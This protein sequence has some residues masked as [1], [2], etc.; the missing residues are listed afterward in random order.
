MSEPITWRTGKTVYRIRGSR[1]VGCGEVYFPPKMFCN[2][3]GRES[4]M[5]DVFFGE[6][7]GDIYTA[8]VNR[9]PTTKF[10]YLEAPFSMYVSFRAN[11][12]RVMVSGRLTDFRASRDEIGIGGFIGEGVVPR[13]RRVYD[14]GLIHYSRLSFSL[15]DDYYETHLARDLEPVV[16][17]GTPSERPGIVGYGAY[18]PKYRIRV[19]EVAE[20]SGKNPD[21]YRGVVKEKALPF[22]DED[23]R[24]FA[25]EA[26][27]RAMFHAGA[28]KNTVDVVSVGTE[29]NPYVVYPVAVSVAEACGLP[30]SVNPYDA[31]FACKAATSQ[32]GLMSGAIQAG[33]YRNALVIGSDNSQARPGDALDYSVGAGAA[34]LL[35][36][37]EG[38]IATLDGVAHYSSD[39]P[40]FYRREGERY[41]SHGQRFTGEQAYFRTVVSAGKSL[42]DRTGLSSGD[43]D[44][45]V[46]HQP[47]MKF[48][49]SAARALGFEKDQYELGNAVDYIGNLYA[50][51]CIAGLCDIL[52]VAKPSERIMMVAYGSGAGSDA[53]VFTVTDEIEGKRERAITLSGQ[54]FNPRREYV[55]YEF[56]RRT[57]EQ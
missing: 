35:L 56:Y 55:S 7:L 43:F 47:N 29:S 8:S 11:G 5:E 50:G 39:T 31:H 23:T 53:Y 57:K 36:G 48:P 44:Y 24:T 12:G 14:D 40:D 25:V 6:S 54:I 41:P 37:S 26:A 38:V 46:A 9:N 15:L 21:L 49:R 45:F 22:L 30:S 10:E 34:A 19:E 18:V 52:D 33:I 20:A 2:N 17:G 16:P 42:L 32:F 3:E 13:F 51:S 27:E 4:R 28:D 1:C